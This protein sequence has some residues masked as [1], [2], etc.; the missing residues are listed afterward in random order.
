MQAA[1]EIAGRR[2]SGRHSDSESP[3]RECGSRRERG[4][5]EEDPED[6]QAALDYSAG[7]STESIASSSVRRLPAATPRSK[8]SVGRWLRSA[9]LAFGEARRGQPGPA[10]P[11]ELSLPCDRKECPA[12][13]THHAM[14]AAG[15]R[16]FRSA[17]CARAAIAPSSSGTSTEG[18]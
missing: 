4:P 17:R 13:D 15:R 1:H 6:G 10:E 16:S 8:A 9:E 7:A 5:A 12:A 14:P 18:R 2:H 11:L 3:A